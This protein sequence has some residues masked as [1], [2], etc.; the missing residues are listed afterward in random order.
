M[1]FGHD[2]PNGPRYAT[3]EMLDAERDAAPGVPTIIATHQ[4]G[5]RAL[6]VDETRIYWTTTYALGSIGDL[7]VKSCAKTDCAGTLVTYWITYWSAPPSG[8]SVVDRLVV[9]KSHVFWTSVSESTSFETYTILSCPIAG[10]NGPPSVIAEPVFPTVLV[11]DDAYLYWLS[12]DATIQKCPVSGCGKKPD[13]VAKLD[14]TANV[15]LVADES[16]LY[17]GTRAG[18]FSTISTVP[19][20]G[21][22]PP[23]VLAHPG[24]Q[25][26][27]LAV[28]ATHVYW[29]ESSRN[30]VYEACPQPRALSSGLNPHGD[31]SVKA[32][33]L[34]GC[35]NEPT[36]LA[37]QI[38][39]STMLHVN[40]DRSYWFT[41]SGERPESF[42]P[43]PSELLERR[44]NDDGSSPSVL[45]TVAGG[46]CDLAVDATHVYWTD[47]GSG[48]PLDGD[49]PPPDG[50]VKRLR[51]R[52]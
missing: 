11:V 39:I 25:P 5:A 43:P 42:Y 8:Y 18:S 21:S 13:R 38:D 49:A 45:T 26:D 29:T 17:W 50:A 20:D 9:N 40:G 27:G 2:N 31:A 34:T 24:D 6:V 30:Y 37:S 32:C 35:V 3:P 51:R 19:K 44:L 52:P 15:A 47:W 1:D 7:S 14:A 46:P 16:H 12:T 22:E 23:R 4:W 10:C 36:V 41:H 48:P 33:P 28:D